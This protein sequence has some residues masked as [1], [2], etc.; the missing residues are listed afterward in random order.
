MKDENGR[1]RKI[2]AEKDYEINYLKKKIDEEKSIIGIGKYELILKFRFIFLKKFNLGPI[3]GDAAATKIVDL[4]KKLREL[5]SS[6]ESEKTKNKQLIQNCS[7]LENQLI[8]VKEKSN[9]QVDNKNN[10]HDEEE[11]EED[12]SDSDINPSEKKL[13]LNKQIKELK[14]KLNQTTHK[15]MEYRSQ[16]EIIKQDLKKTQKVKIMLIKNS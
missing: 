3:S 7:N 10:N 16:S 14:D 11:E 8:K 6:Y 15:M 1:L 5:T 13:S 4:A 9:N 12:E 2:I